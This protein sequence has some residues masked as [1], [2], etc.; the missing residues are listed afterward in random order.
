[1][2]DLKKEYPSQPMVGV[3]ALI[4][5][6][7]KI[8]I[9]KRAYEPAKNMW[10]LPGGTI[11]PGEFSKDSIRREINEEL[12]IY[13]EP[14]CIVDVEEYIERDSNNKV[15]YHF[16]ILVYF[17]EV[18]KQDKLSLSDEISDIKWVTSVEALSYNLTP[19]TKVLIKK[20]ISKKLSCV[21]S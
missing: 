4:V 20:F 11:E 3:S 10:S 18:F 7:D 15:R 9:V 5:Y 12:G 8:L 14:R 21:D 13:I 1:M 16:V 6:R 17:V 19:T 2:N